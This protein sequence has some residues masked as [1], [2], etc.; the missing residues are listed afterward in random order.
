MIKVTTITT[1][2]TTII[3][4]TRTLAELD[5]KMQYFAAMHDCSC[6]FTDKLQSSSLWNESQTVW[7]KSWSTRAKGSSW[8]GV[9]SFFEPVTSLY[10]HTGRGGS[11]AEPSRLVR[12]SSS[13]LETRVIW[14][15]LTR[16]WHSSHSSTFH[17]FRHLLSIYKSSELSSTSRT[18]APRFLSSYSLT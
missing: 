6:L 3:T 13:Q 17:E 4:T 2:V 8:P 16:R 14:L 7:P 11:R 12:S 15:T 1:R 10:L 5:S 9:W 18:K